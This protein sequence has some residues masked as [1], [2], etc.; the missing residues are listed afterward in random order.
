M[1]AERLGVLGLGN[2]AADGGQVRPEAPP[3]ANDK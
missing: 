3:L 1:I 2:T